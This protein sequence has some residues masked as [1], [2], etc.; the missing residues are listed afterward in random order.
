M[1]AT[2]STVPMLTS[3]HLKRTNVMPTPHALMTLAL[4][5]VHVTLATM[6][7]A[8]IVPMSMNALFH[9]CA[10]LLRITATLMPAVS[11]LM[12]VTNADAMM[13]MMAM[14]SIVPILMSVISNSTYATPMPRVLMI[15]AVTIVRVILVSRVTASIVPILTSVPS[16]PFNEPYKVYA[17][18]MPAA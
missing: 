8:L 15:S 1:M 7:M 5:I 12:A 16:L 9:N 13:V 14:G 3:V 2:G 11:T 10:L 4:I 18:S 6:E 17:I